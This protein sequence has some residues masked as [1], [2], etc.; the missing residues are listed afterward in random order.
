MPNT[1][2][3]AVNRILEKAKRLI[4]IS[5]KLKPINN[6]SD[7]ALTKIDQIQKIQ[8]DEIIPRCEKLKDNIS[9]E[10]RLSIQNQIKE[11]CV[12]SQELCKW[13]HDN[14]QGN[15]KNNPTDT[16]VVTAVAMRE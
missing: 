11:L 15:I 8:N 14:Y 1:N 10:E 4:E 13:I 12:Q 9:Q 6:N 16:D 2:Y 5:G 3:E 7:E